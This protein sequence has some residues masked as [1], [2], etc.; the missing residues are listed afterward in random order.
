[1]PHFY[2][3]HQEIIMAIMAGWNALLRVGTTAVDGRVHSA[4]WMMGGCVHWT[5]GLQV[6]VSPLHHCSSLLIWCLTSTPSHWY[7]LSRRRGPRVRAWRECAGWSVITNYKVL[8]P[9]PGLWGLLMT[10]LATDPHHLSCLHELKWN[11]QTTFPPPS[12][13][14]TNID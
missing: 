10:S 7:Q 14:V 3:R 8:T 5:A 11:S 4:V 12:Q 13:W 6:S 9:G 2:W 1:M